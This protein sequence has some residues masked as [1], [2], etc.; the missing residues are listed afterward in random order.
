MLA[1]DK[2][3]FALTLETLA[4]KKSANI[5][6]FEQVKKELDA[7]LLEG[8]DK[9]EDLPKKGRQRPM[10]TSIP[11]LRVKHK[12]MKDQWVKITDK[13]K[14]DSGKSPVDE[15]E[16]FKILDPIFSETHAELKIATKGSD[17]LSEDSGEDGANLGFLLN[18]TPPNAS[19]SA[20][21]KSSSSCCK[22]SCLDLS[23]FL[24]NFYLYIF[25]FPSTLRITTKGSLRLTSIT[26]IH[27]L[28]RRGAKAFVVD[29][30]S[31]QSLAFFSLKV[32][33]VPYLYLS[34]LTVRRLMRLDV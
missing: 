31:F 8:K 34:H 30:I 27:I 18:N 2:S 7:R 23:P 9:E 10:N 16:W 29:V 11:K 21:S 19:A 17:M 22:N 24:I 5:H 1:D 12:W 13:M 6:I 25:F 33:G 15:P 20:I 26:A 14:V 3:E 4:L 32:K 28:A